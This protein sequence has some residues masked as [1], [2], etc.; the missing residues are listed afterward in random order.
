MEAN[1]E[2]IIAF[3]EANEID[4]VDFLYDNA[5]I[6]TNEIKELKTEINELKRRLGE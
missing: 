4:I 2:D 1:K 6:L 3:C 5:E